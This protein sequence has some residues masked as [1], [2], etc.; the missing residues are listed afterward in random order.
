[1]TRISTQN[2]LI[3]IG[4]L[5]VAAIFGGTCLIISM[6]RQAAIGAFQTAADNLGN[7]MAQQ[8]AHFM[9]QADKVMGTVESRVVA[10]PGLDL[11]AIEARMQSPSVFGLLWQQQSRLAGVEGLILV[12]A[13]GRVANNAQS[14]PATPVDVS[15][16]DYF[17]HFK[18]GDDP[19]LFVGIPVRDPASGDWTVPLAR[20]I[21]A[22]H[23]AFAGVVMAELSLT[24]LAAF[25]QLA[26]PARQTLYLAR[27]DGVVLLRD[28]ARPAEIGRR[29]PPG[30]PWYAVL[31]AGGGVY[32]GPAYFSAAPVVAAVRPLPNLPLVVEASCTQQDALMKWRQGRIW[33]VL[34]GT[35]TALFAIGILRLFGWQ[36]ER[37]EMSERNLATKNAELDLA[38]R[39]MEATLANLNQGVCFFDENNNLL[40]FNRRFCEVIGLP[41]EAVRVGM[42]TGEIAAMRIAAGTFW[43]ETLEGYLA[44]IEARLRAGVPV[45][46]ISELAD[47]RTVSKHFEPVAGHGWVMTLEDISERRA[48]E[49]KIA[50][51]A[52]HD[53]LTGLANRALFRDRLGHAFTDTSPNKSF[54]MLCLDLDRF[55]AVNDTYGHGVG[56]GLLCAV[57]DRLRAAL[58]AGDTVARLGGDE[59][60]ILQLNVSDQ[61]ETV[62]LA[63]RIVESIGRPFMI[64]GHMLSVG[65]SIGIAM[66]PPHRLNPERLLQDA[67]LA[68]YRSKQAGRG[69]WR[70]FDATMEAADTPRRAV[71]GEL[72]ESVPLDGG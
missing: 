10:V 21:D 33:V 46:E 1:M 54:A 51:L 57:A 59:F 36:F 50:Y 42:S 4:T 23:G 68:L 29:I 20:R 53:L 26:M 12:G 70:I 22:A 47:G 40:V 18:A 11:A 45:D 61:S 34:G 9:T 39:Q 60:V 19:G 43:D 72:A 37:I 28:P 67:D 58:R 3:L 13:D 8:T 64:E 2:Q 52:H 31:A 32:D 6:Q 56:D 14:W 48:A 16:S 63:R 35:L 55:K 62:A 5:I 17:R 27:R 41:C 30:S 44:T 15:G 7:G 25:Y 65:V 69:T 66:A 24:D 38:H 49:Q 71:Q